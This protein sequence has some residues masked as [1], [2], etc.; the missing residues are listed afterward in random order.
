[1]LWPASDVRSTTS[2][3]ISGSASVRQDGRVKSTCVPSNDRSTV[4][5]PVGRAD[6]DGARSTLFAGVGGAGGGTG[7]A[8]GGRTVVAGCAAGGAAGRTVVVCLGTGII[9]GSFLTRVGGRNAPFAPGRN[10]DMPAIPVNAGPP[11]PIW[12]VISAR[13]ARLDPTIF[14][15]P[16]P[17]FPTPR[18]RL[19]SQSHLGCV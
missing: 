6:G 15:T 7:A 16:T 8:A 12:L 2:P 1:M 10:I 9:G 17:T 13:N 14:R 4:P 11:F 19:C 18:L 3:S 5:T